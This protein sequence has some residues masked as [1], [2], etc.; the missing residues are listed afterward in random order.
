VLG[1]IVDERFSI[2]ASHIIQLKLFHFFRL[3]K[4]GFFNLLLE[5]NLDLVINADELILKNRHV[6][7]K[8]IETK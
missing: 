8:R 3:S 5:H 4:I 1:K 7:N 2:T 6:I